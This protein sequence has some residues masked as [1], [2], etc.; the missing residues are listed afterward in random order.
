MAHKWVRGTQAAAIGD[1][2]VRMSVSE[3]TLSRRNHAIRFSPAFQVCKLLTVGWLEFI[4]AIVG[5]IA[6][7]AAVVWV[8]FLLRHQIRALLPS[9]SRVQ[10]GPFQ[11]DFRQRLEE[12]EQTKQQLEDRE[13]KALPST[14]D[15]DEDLQAQRE[16]LYARAQESPY[17]AVVSAWFSVLAEAEG[18]AIRNKLR[19]ER[20]VLPLRRTVEMLVER[21]KVPRLLIEYAAQLA[22]LH[23]QI[24]KTESA[25]RGSITVEEA[26]RY[27]DLCLRLNAYLKLA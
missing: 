25:A 8:V 19:E 24:M 1:A 14:E 15:L 11:A 6:W 4:A 7:P 16:V 10:L 26:K 20:P 5:S 13:Q 9:L 22:R 23:E 17:E 21:E 3:N 2:G 18:A 27:I 12:A